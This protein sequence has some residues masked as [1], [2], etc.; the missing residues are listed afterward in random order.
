MIFE[1]LITLLFAAAV[2]VF[3]AVAFYTAK[4]KSPDKDPGI[5]VLL[6]IQNNK[7]AWSVVIT[8]CLL[9]SECI[10]AGTITQVG[11][12][13]SAF[14]GRL[15]QHVVVSLAGFVFSMG[16]FNYLA[17][18]FNKFTITDA[19]LTA[20]CLVLMVAAPLA[21]LQLIAAGY[22]STFYL[23]EFWFQHSTSS[24]DWLTYLH[25]RNLPEEY[26]S[27]D[28]M[29]YPLLGCLYA[30]IL[31]FFVIIYD[32]IVTL[33]NISVVKSE[34][35]VESTAAK[36]AKKDDFKLEGEMNLP[37][38]DSYAAQPGFAIATSFILGNI[39]K[40]LEDK[41][42][43][44]LRVVA[45]LDAYLKFDEPGVVSED[46]FSAIQDKITEFDTTITQT[47][48]NAETIKTIHE[49]FIKWA[50]SEAE[51]NNPGLGI[52]HKKLKSWVYSE[53]TLKLFKK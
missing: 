45:L 25:S 52:K 15:V 17:T 47:S 50:C 19:F 23:T 41:N 3:M 14:I 18:L 4:K 49:K 35:T 38:L 22:K 36:G 46:I 30:N 27:T 13:Q 1:N 2:I 16:F 9:L 31:N 11:E 33:R 37:D 29:P 21:N 48:G 7:V 12:V 44:H 24:A 26:S 34:K 40:K 53:E 20:F 32:S 5:D 39:V 28:R 42:N 51:G 10:I 43:T 8:T 6:S